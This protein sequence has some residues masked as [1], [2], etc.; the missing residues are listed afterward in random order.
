M[1][2]ATFILGLIG[3][4][5]G[6]IS[7]IL[8]LLIGLNMKVT[9]PH[10]TQTLIFGSL[11]LLASIAGLIG[12]CIAQNKNKLAGILM[13]IATI[14]NIVVAFTSISANSPLNFLMGLLVA[15]LF[16]ISTIFAFKI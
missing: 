11:G 3:G 1:K 15:I 4:I 13:T 8:L 2:K 12:A 16:L 10:G 9:N 14:F 6:I 7:C 5:I